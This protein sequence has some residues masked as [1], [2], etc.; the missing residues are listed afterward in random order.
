MIYSIIIDIV[1]YFYWKISV[2]GLGLFDY[3]MQGIV[4]NAKDVLLSVLFF[5][6]IV[7]INKILGATKNENRIIRCR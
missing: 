7:V 4:F 3:I 2:Y 6:I 1:S 5:S